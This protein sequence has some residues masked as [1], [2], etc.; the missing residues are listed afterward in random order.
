[1][2]ESDKRTPRLIFSDEER[3]QIVRNFVEA[4]LANEVQLDWPT[5]EHY[6]QMAKE[7]YLSGKF[8][9]VKLE[10]G[11]KQSFNESVIQVTGYKEATYDEVEA[12]FTEIFDLIIL[13]RIGG[14][15]KGSFFKGTKVE[16]RLKDL[17]DKVASHGRLIESLRML[18]HVEG[19]AN[20]NVPQV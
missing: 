5:K 7:G 17:E 8:A 15:I 14:R 13:A 2:S 3:R 19:N 6:A 16:Q 11:M 12:A 10:T 18:E 9:P 4:F 20:D 1:M